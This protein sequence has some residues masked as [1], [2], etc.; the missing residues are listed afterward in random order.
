MTNYTRISLAS[1]ALAASLAFTG[2][3]AADEE[4][5]FLDANS[6][7]EDEAKDLSIVDPLRPI[8]KAIFNFNDFV[9]LKA[10]K[11]V[12]KGYQAIMPDQAEKSVGNFFNNLK[13]PSRLVGN[14][15]LV[16]L[17]QATQETG[18][19]LVDTTIGIGGL[20]KPSKDIDGLNPPKE[21][22]GQ[23]LASW[24]LG[25]GF[26]VVLPF[27]GPTSLRDGIGNFGDSYVEP[28]PEPW[29]QVD[30]SAVRLGLQGL[31]IIND[32]PTL[33]EAYEALKESA[34]DP[35][36]AMK[37]AYLQRRNAQTDQ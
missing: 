14:L 35:Y 24:G 11:P 26:Y 12:S 19:F 33:L 9:Y 28:I 6:L 16:K 22:I 17:K 27:S 31:E 21:D 7:F 20:L 2:G 15:M 5:E 23:G 1:L 3:L 36:E 18:K 34:I 25:H 32:S 37:D 8:N 13:Y 10:L 30:E 4:E 29:S